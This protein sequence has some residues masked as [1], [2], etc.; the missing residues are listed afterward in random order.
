MNDA[1]RGWLAGIIDGEGCIT[2]SKQQ[3]GTGGRVSPSHRLYL[4]VTMGH[5]ETINHCLELT[6]RGSVHIQRHPHYNDAWS[7]LVAG[8]EA[9]GVIRQVYDLLIT[10]R[11]E[12]DVALEFAAL[13]RSMQGGS[14][15]TKRLHPS[16]IA[17]RESCFERLRD[18]KP[19]ARFRKVSTE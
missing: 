8:N 4:K 15:G 10:K 6:G 5:L 13:P 1:Q 11:E 12:A 19:S 14:G 18:L 17:A 2:I 16:Y 3:P 9:A 7:W